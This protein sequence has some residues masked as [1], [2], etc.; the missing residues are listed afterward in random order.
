MPLTLDVA[1]L[2]SQEILH[3]LFLMK[4]GEKFCDGWKYSFTATAEPC[5]EFDFRVGRVLLGCCLIQYQ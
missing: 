5:C 4:A 1:F 2:N 3:V